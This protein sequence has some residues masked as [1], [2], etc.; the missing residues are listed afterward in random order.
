V[1]EIVKAGE[2]AEELVRQLLAFGRRQVLRPEVLDLN[3][4]LGGVERMLRRVIGANIA[5]ITVPGR[6]AA[7]VN[8]DPGQIEQVIVNLAV[9]AR[10]AMPDGGKLIFEVSFADLDAEDAE[11]RPDVQP[12]PYVMLAVSDTGF[13][14]EP[15]VQ[16]RIFEPFFTTKEPGQGTGLGLATVYGIVKQ[17]GGNIS[18]YSEPGSGTTFRIYLPR[19]AGSQTATARNAPPAEIPR[20]DETVLL[21]EDRAS[22]RRF[23]RETL[24][25]QG[26]TVLE[27]GRGDEALRVVEEHREPIHLLITDLVMPGMSGTALAERVRASRLNVK[28]LFMSGYSD[29]A[30]GRAWLAGAGEH[31]V[32]KP[33]RPETLARKVR[34]VLESDSGQPR[35]GEGNDARPPTHVGGPS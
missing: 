34:E 12:G 24:E 6:E 21:V 17:S 11:A 18:V 23:A 22:V 30:A 20:G 5:L 3:A 28:V 1:T 15:E 8:A 16:E 29:E 33:F 10:D 19:V 35:D 14:I 27:A 32:A 4:S 25:A 26:Y 2:R 7:W 31:F 9:N 13:G